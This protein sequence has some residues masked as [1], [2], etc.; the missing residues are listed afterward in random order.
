VE[1]PARLEGRNLVLLM[2]PRS[3][4]LKPVTPTTNVKPAGA[5]RPPAKKPA[6]AAAAAVKQSSTPSATAKPTAP[7]S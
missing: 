3:A 5:A 6:A 7:R 1:N 2:V 4:V